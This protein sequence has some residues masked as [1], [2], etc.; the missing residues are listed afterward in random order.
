MK[1]QKKIT[2]LN[3]NGQIKANLDMIKIDFDNFEWFTCLFMK[4][5]I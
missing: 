3:S 2:A 4:G 5:Q 1:N